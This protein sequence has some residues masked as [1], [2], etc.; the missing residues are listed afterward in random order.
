MEMVLSNAARYICSWRAM[1]FYSSAR[2]GLP[3][4]GHW[5][6]PPSAQLATS[7]RHY[8]IM[9]L[10]TQRKQ[11][12]HG[13]RIQMDRVLSRTLLVV[14][15][16]RR[17]CCGGWRCMCL[18]WPWLIAAIRHIPCVTCNHPGHGGKALNEQQAAGE[19]T[20][21]AGLCGS[22]H[23]PILAWARR[24]VAALLEGGRREHLRGLYRLFVSQRARPFLITAAPSPPGTER[25]GICECS[26]QTAPTRRPSKQQAVC[27]AL[28]IVRPRPLRARRCRRCRST[29]CRSGVVRVGP[30]SPLRNPTIHK[31]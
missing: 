19:R 29:N 22:V 30:R 13:C 17:H 26:K 24:H 8:K 23:A 31:R 7:C 25:A 4:L 18:G 12:R 15:R 20:Y 10:R 5:N 11:Q 16:R 3:C 28:Q 9:S 6:E 1:T 2:P 27:T 21:D 14:A